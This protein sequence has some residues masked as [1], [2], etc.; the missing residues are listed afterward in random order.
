ML[1]QDMVG[2]KAPG[3]DTMRVMN[4]F[5]DPQLTQFIRTLITTYTP[6]PV[7]NDVCV[8]ACSDH[9]AFFEVGYKSAIQSE[10]VLARG[11][12]TENDVIEDIDFEY[13]N[14]FCKVAVAYAIEISEP[15]KY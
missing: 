1:Q 3:V 10:T 9:A 2:Y 6:F 7:K 14:E 15:S 11:Y 12:H 5:S 4:D 13:F 8:Y